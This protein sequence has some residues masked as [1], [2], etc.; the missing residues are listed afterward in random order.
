MGKVLYDVSMSLDGYVAGPNQS[1]EHPLG[2][3]GELLH[4]WMRTL[5]VWRQAAGLEGGEVNPNSAVLEEADEA[6][7]I[8][9]RNMFGGG[10]GPWPTD[11][12]WTGWWGDDPPFHCPVFVLTHHPRPPLQCHGGTTFT[13]VTDGIES[14][15]TQAR[16]AARDGNIGIGGGTTAAQYLSHGLIDEVT[17][18]LVPLLLGSGVRLMDLVDR[19]AVRLEQ[20][21]VRDGPGVVHIR[22]RVTVPRP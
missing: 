20:I 19:T 13:F 21:A 22:Y 16:E 7:V 5:S 1:R 18:H 9:G 11:P 10:P 4:E 6:A 17:I 2:V 12:P 14:A 15:L 8:M 3:G